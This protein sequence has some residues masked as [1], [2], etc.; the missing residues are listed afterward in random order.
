MIP[1]NTLKS[2]VTHN[3]TTNA[4]SNV[5]CSYSYILFYIYIITVQYIISLYNSGIYNNYSYI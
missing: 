3:A 1:K 4:K 2:N 5:N